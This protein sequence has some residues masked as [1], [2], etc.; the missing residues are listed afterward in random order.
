[1]PTKHI[2]DGTAAELDELYV[3][4]VTLTQQPVKEVEVLR[5]AIQTGIGNITDNDILSSMSVKDS[6]WKRL[7]EKTWSEITA[8]WP[9]DV[10]VAPSFERLAGEHSA[11]WQSLSSKTCRVEL[12]KRLR[13][14]HSGLLSETECQLFGYD[15]GGMTDEQLQEKEA[16]D[17]QKD[18]E[19]RGGLPSLAGRMYSSLS[20]HEKLLVRYYHKN[21]NFTPDGQGDFKIQYQEDNP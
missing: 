7:A 20:E 1:M 10:I 17:K 13:E 8:C 5:L 12:I 18:T 9:E 2:D 19:F 16:E 6:V 14:E 11:T 15:Y 21:I 3:R 4:C